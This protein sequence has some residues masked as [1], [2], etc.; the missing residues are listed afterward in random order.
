DRG[1]LGEIYHAR[2]WMLRRAGLPNRVS[3]LKREH[4]GGGPCIDIGVHILDLTLWM[5]GHPTPVSVVGTSQN[6]LASQE[7]SFTVLGQPRPV[8]RDE[9]D[10]EDFAA[11]MVRFDNGATLMLEVSWMLHHQVEGRFEDMQMWLYGTD[12]GSHWPRCEFYL[13]DADA[14]QHETRRL[15]LLKD[16]MEPHAAECVAFAEAIAEGGPS[17]VPAE[18]S[19]AVQK[20]LAGLYQSQETGAE[21]R[22]D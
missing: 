8:L 6:R 15:E 9:M 20:I 18:Q 17:P 1:L 16:A 4:A 19:L 11:A 22:L 2:A 7:G 12:A 13:A 21:V 14:M 5:M 10:V 3:F